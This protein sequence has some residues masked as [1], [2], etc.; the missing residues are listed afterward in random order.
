MA[1]PSIRSDQPSAP[2]ARIPTA[3]GARAPS[4]SSRV[5]RWAS[6]WWTILVLLA[7]AEAAALG[8]RVLR[9]APPSDWQRASLSVR[10]RLREGDVVAVAP[11]WANPLLRLE[12][13]D[14]MPSS[15]VGRSD[16]AAYDRLWV[17]SVRGARAPEAPVRAPDLREHYG[18]VLLERYDFAPTAVTLDLVDAL[19][20]AEVD[21]TERSKTRLCRWQA[22]NTKP[23]RGGLGHGPAAPAQRFVCDPKR[24]WLWVGATVLEDLDLRARRCVWQHP[25]GKQPVGVTYRDVHL[26]THMVLHGGLYYRHERDGKGAPVYLRVTVDGREVARFRHSDGDG[27]AR[28]EVDTLA[29]RPEDA[30]ARGDVRIEVTTDRPHHR[31]FCWSGSIRDARRREAP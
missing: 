13:G 30:P 9:V 2:G 23:V 3:S 1:S 19:P 15:M 4:G 21:I 20:R 10:E 16:L 12:L 18:R 29:G 14:R 26:G 7:L 24:S 5:P 31:S 28:Y 8:V 11:H 25:V 17:F 27:F 6:P 22:R